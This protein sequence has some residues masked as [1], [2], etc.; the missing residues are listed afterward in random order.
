MIVSFPVGARVGVPLKVPD[1]EMTNDG[2]FVVVPPPDGEMMIGCKF[3]GAFGIATSVVGEVVVGGGRVT[4]LGGRVVAET[5][6][7]GG[8]V[9]G[10]ISKPNGGVVEVGR[11]GIGGKVTG[12]PP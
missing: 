2:V 6:R 12:T 7:I 8:K 3:V 4:S 11:N 10:C 9:T 1:G 5:I